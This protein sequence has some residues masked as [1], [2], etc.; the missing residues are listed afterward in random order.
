VSLHPTAVHESGHVVSA[1]LLGCR[2]TSATIHADG[3]GRAYLEDLSHRR[4]VLTSL[5][6]HLAEKLLI[7]L[8]DVS[9]ARS[10]GDL[11]NAV[12]HALLIAKASDHARHARRAATAVSAAIQLSEEK[13]VSALDALSPEQLNA[14]IDVMMQRRTARALKIVDAAEAAVT[15]MLAANV[16]VLR[17]VA[18]A[19]GERGVLGEEE[20]LQL[21]AEGRARQIQ[22]DERTRRKS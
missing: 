15:D 11:E 17:T 8:A 19:L 16:L 18:K 12:R 21:F 7:P 22:D 1:L 4:S 20:I 13:P 10:R 2:V 9:T 14:A 3:S 6:G 5:G